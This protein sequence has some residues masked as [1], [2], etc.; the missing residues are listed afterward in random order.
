MKKKVLSF[1]LCVVM[2]FSI[3][4]CSNKG[5]ESNNNITN[6]P[7]ATKAPEATQPPVEEKLGYDFG[8][9]KTFHSDEPVTYSMFF[10]DASWYPMVERWET[11]GLFAKIKELTNVTLNVTKIDSGD[12]DNKKAL[13]INTGESAYIIH[14]MN[15][16]LLMVAL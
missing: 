1:V 2:V 15:L 4:A 12:Y 7:T 5:K 13:M 3:A 14:M 10:S 9:D 16:H 6:E 8:V 11:E